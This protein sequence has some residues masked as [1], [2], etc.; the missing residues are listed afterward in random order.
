MAD[1]GGA[2][3][4]YVSFPC[5]TGP[6]LRPWSSEQPA[7]PARYGLYGR[8]GYVPD[9]R[10]ACQGQRPLRKG[11]L[12]TMDDDLIIWL[13]KHLATADLSTAH[14]RHKRSGPSVAPGR[15]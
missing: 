3:R 8:R 9:G 4:T 5:P 2:R 10:G 7:A 11:M 1:A 15:D 12:V 14:Q 13:T 6:N